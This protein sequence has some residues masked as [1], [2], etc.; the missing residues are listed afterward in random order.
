MKKIIALV[1]FTQILLADSIYFMPYDAK[2]AI[3]SLIKE[4]KGAKNNVKI[5]I[6]S[7]TNREISKAIRDSAKNG[8][9]Y[10]IIFDYKSNINE[11]TS[12]IGYLAKLKN[13]QT[14]TLQGK[15]SYND[16]YNGIMHNKLAIIDDETIIF[17]SANWSKAAFELNY[18]L[19]VISRN[20][21]YIN[22]ANN[23]FEKML[24]GCK[25]F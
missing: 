21:D 14:C 10:Q 16:K 9:K 24:K 7:F 20:K 22:Q 11:S 6:Y 23:Y 2:N 12:Q 18:E 13:I 15:R 4:I 19:M 5:S 25:P 3:N 8:V 17:G 1:I